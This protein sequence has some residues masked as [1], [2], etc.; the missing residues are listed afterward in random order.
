MW[1]WVFAGGGIGS[2]EAPAKRAIDLVALALITR[3]GTI[4]SCSRKGEASSSW[5]GQAHERTPNHVHHAIPAFSTNGLPSALGPQ[6]YPSRSLR[7]GHASM[8]L[9]RGPP[10]PLREA[11]SYSDEEG[12][13]TLMRRSHRTRVG[14]SSALACPRGARRA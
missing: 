1:W 13:G 4:W 8:S 2:N 7:R 5:R 6:A 10:R 9:S 12:H 14:L 11:L 3:M